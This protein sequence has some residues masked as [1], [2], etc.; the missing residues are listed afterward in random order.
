MQNKEEDVTVPEEK[1]DLQKQIERLESK[2]ISK[3]DWMLQG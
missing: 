3:K 1:N 2:I